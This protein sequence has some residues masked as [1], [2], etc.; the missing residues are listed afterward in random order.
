[1]NRMVRATLLTATLSIAW[2]LSGSPV[3]AETVL[4]AITYAPP[5]KVEDSMVVF[6][7]WVDRVN[8]AGKGALRINHLGGPEVFPVADQINATNKGL[9]DIVMTFSVHTAL[10]PEI[11][12]TGLSDISIEEERKLAMS[13]SSTKLTRR[14]TS[15]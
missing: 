6:L 15:R 4:R 9:V 11:D 12:T 14:S 2:S 7:D 13:T 1:M 5:N 10:V 8:K 3:N